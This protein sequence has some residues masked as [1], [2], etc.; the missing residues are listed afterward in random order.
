MRYLLFSLLLFTVGALTISSSTEDVP[1]TRKSLL[2]HD[3]ELEKYELRFL[4][5]HDEDEEDEEEGN[6]EDSN[7][8]DSWDEWKRRMEETDGKHF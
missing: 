8:G 1:V 6:Y 2:A 5:N 4:D 3:N 7:A